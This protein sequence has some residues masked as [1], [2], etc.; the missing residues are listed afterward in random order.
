MPVSRTYN[1][2]SIIYFQ[3]DR[4]EDIYVLQEG[5]VVLNSTDIETGVEIKEEVKQGEFFGVKS[6]LGHYP[7]EETAQVAGK[8]T[9]FIFSLKEFEGFVLQNTRLILKMAQ[10]FSKQLRAIHRKVRETLNVGE[11]KNPEYELANV[12]ESFYRMGNFD[13][14]CSAFEKYLHYYPQ[15]AYV[16]RIQNLVGMCKNGETYPSGLAP[17]DIKKVDAL[18]AGNGTAEAVKP[19]GLVIVFSEGKQ[20]FK[21]GNFEESLQAFRR[22]V[23]WK[24]PANQKEV[25]FQSRAIYECGRTEL[26][27]KKNNE[28]SNHF[29]LYLKK[30]PSGSMARDCI[31]HLGL[32]SELKG[33]QGKAKKLYNKLLS[34]TVKDETSAKARNRL[35]KLS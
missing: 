26:K 32:I 5:R 34:T 8:T 31:F 25:E 23:N 18:K 30:H 9:L 33:E 22:C 20:L 16:E 15:G 12:A 10:V 1:G 35:E 3:G 14:A 4:G 27:M 28:A 2:G 29:S 19:Q 13:H 11:A 24:K 17:L 7:R 6:S 21:A